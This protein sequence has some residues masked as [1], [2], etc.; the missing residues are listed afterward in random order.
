MADFEKAFKKIIAN[1]G[2][3]VNDKDDKGGETFMGIT[4]KN[5]PKAAVWD[6]IDKYIDMYNSTY[7]LVKYIKNNEV[8]MNSIKSIYKKQYWDK[9]LL[10]KINSQL[11]ANELFDD[12]VNR[13]VNATLRLIR[14][15]YKFPTKTTIL[16]MIPTINSYA[17]K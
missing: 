15:L 8:A 2:G 11:I 13:G 17:R 9:L 3:Y 6:I 10:D 5:H 12:C 4:R 1:E 16:E 7:G 14:K